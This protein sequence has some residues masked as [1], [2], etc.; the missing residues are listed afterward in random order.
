MDQHPQRSAT[1][2]LLTSAASPQLRWRRAFRGEEAQLSQLR[3]WIRSLL[4][5][6]SARDDVLIVASELGTNAIQHTATGRGGWF[7]TEITWFSQ[8]VRVAVGDYGASTGPRLAADA[9]AE[10]G[11][12]LVVVRGLSART[13]VV[14]DKRGRLVWADVLWHDG[15]AQADVMLPSRHEAAIQQ[16]EADLAH[17]FGDGQAWFGRTT[18]NWWALA[19]PTRLISA[20][21]ARSLAIKLAR[22]EDKPGSGR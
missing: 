11:R 19:G 18:L 20:P 6:C 9:L 1:D 14:G 2:P 15:P 13:G 5:E 16:G 17:R 10:N 7:I 21:T 12:G 4:P 22:A 8:A 3:A